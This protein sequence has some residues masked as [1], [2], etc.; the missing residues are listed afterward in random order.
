MIIKVVSCQTVIEDHGEICQEIQFREKKKKRKE[1]KD[2]FL[3]KNIFVNVP[4][5]DKDRQI[6]LFKTEYG[7]ER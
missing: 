2:Q 3:V 5:I 4:H 7:Q 1:T 6:Q